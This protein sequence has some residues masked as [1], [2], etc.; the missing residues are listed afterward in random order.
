MTWQKDSCYFLFQ[1]SWLFSLVK[2]FY[3]R[4]TI[5]IYFFCTIHLFF[6]DSI[7][8]V[9]YI[10]IPGDLHCKDLRMSERLCEF[11]LIRY[12]YLLVNSPWKTSN[13]C[14]HIEPSFMKHRE[15]ISFLCQSETIAIATN[16]RFCSSYVW[17][18]IDI[19]FQ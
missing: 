19:C 8:L 10:N 7:G 12:G 2:I 9:N 4:K 13:N 1:R 6:E 15:E 11:Y 3:M 16:L 18:N 14:W 17:L 5:G